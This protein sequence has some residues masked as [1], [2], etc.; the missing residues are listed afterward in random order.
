MI[1]RIFTCFRESSVL[2]N[3][4]SLSSYGCDV[5][6]QFS[7]ILH[8]WKD[9]ALWLAPLVTKLLEYRGGCIIFMNYSAI[10]DGSNYLHALSNWRN[11]SVDLTQKLREM[12][13][14]GINPEKIFMYGYSIGGRLVIDAALN[15]GPD[16][17]GLIDGEYKKINNS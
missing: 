8:G 16:K 1:K 14:E 15:F 13:N 11:L 4:S 2:V 5:D 9:S 3:G 10:I 6:G 7:I 12:E 17:I